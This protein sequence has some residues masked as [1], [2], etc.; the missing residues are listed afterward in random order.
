MPMLA[1][2]QTEADP[3][4]IVF[5]FFTVLYQLKTLMFSS[6]TEH[7]LLLYGQFRKTFS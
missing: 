7:K 1:P 5:I 6:G 2:K 3:A 4:Q